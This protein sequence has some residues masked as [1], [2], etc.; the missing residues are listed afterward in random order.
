[1]YKLSHQRCYKRPMKI[2]NL[3]NS[4]KNNAIQ[5]KFYCNGKLKQKA[6]TQWRIFIRN[7]TRVKQIASART[8]RPIWAS[9]FTHYTLRQFF[10]WNVLYFA[11][12]ER[13]KYKNEHK[14]QKDET[15]GKR[16]I[17]W[18]MDKKNEHRRFKLIRSPSSLLFPKECVYI[19][20]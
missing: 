9:F 2:F 6:T 14:P 3:E 7:L 12:T 19:V 4:K 5:P 17:F 1:M 20:Q 11:A 10:Y 16:K 18:W 15:S 8:Q 13:C